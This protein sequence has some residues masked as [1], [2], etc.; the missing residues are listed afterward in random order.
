MNFFL[1]VV[2]RVRLNDVVLLHATNRETYLYRKSL[3]SLFLSSMKENLLHGCTDQPFFLETSRSIF[4]KTHEM[5]VVFATA[6][7]DR[8]MLFAKEI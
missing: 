7:I 6:S 8:H 2:P 1:H 3:C 5:S 4:N